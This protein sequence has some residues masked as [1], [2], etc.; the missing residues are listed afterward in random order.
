MSRE[1]FYITTPIFYPNGKPHIPGSLDVW[2]N[3][4]VSHPHGKYDGKLTKAARKKR[5]MGVWLLMARPIKPSRGTT[6][7]ATRSTTGSRWFPGNSGYA[8]AAGR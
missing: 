7:R 6:P 3:L 5:N 8:A 1:K 2:K 4:F